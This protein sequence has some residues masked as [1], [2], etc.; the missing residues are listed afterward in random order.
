M[1]FT[2]FQP[3]MHH[4]PFC[5]KYFDSISNVKKGKIIIFCHQNIIREIP[6]GKHLVYLIRNKTAKQVILNFSLKLKKKLKVIFFF[7]FFKKYFSPL[8]SYGFYR[9]RF[10]FEV[11]FRKQV[12]QKKTLRIIFFQLDSSIQKDLEKSFLSNTWINKSH[13]L[14]RNRYLQVHNYTS[15]ENR[16]IIFYLTFTIAPQ[17]RAQRLFGIISDFLIL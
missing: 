13:G 16:T 2:N 17:R 15:A 12:T 11:S 1:N 14:I 9:F 10:V 4:L 6:K 7:I 8:I 3:L 5:P